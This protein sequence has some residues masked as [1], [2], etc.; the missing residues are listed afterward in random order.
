MLSSR[1]AIDVSHEADGEA[2]CPEVCELLQLAMLKD[3]L[4]KVIQLLSARIVQRGC[5]CSVVCVLLCSCWSILSALLCICCAV[6]STLFCSCCSLCCSCRCSA[7]AAS[8][9]AA[10]HL[11]A[12]KAVKWLGRTCL[13]LDNLAAGAAWHLAAGAAA[14]GQ[15]HCWG[16]Q[17]WQHWQSLSQSSTG[18]SRKTTCPVRPAGQ[19]NSRTCQDYLTL[20]DSSSSK[21]FTRQLRRPYPL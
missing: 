10:A 8:C 13:H 2:L 12:R 15:L 5:S 21:I 11:A 19:F 6:L 16:C 4:F 9:S 18:P 17:C 1:K 7:A 3:F 14:A 20:Q